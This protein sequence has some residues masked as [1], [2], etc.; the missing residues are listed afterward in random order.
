MGRN[1]GIWGLWLRYQ[2]WSW[3][4]PGSH[5]PLRRTNAEPGEMS[6]KLLV[7]AVLAPYG[8]CPVSPRESPMV[9]TV[10]QVGSPL[11]EFSHAAPLIGLGAER[12][13]ASSP[14]CTVRQR[15]HESG[16]DG[17]KFA[18][19][20]LSVWPEDSRIC[21]G[22]LPIAFGS[23]VP[24]QALF[25]ARPLVGSCRPAHN[26]ADRRIVRQRRKATPRGAHSS[27]RRKRRNR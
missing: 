14:L 3:E 11:P 13:I 9:F 27:D 8:L 1:G 25:R 17:R 7:L 19:S 5:D 24:F 6:M 22:S 23:S 26:S 16:V 15:H 12:E 4:E 10:R 21:S 2:L 18:S 20:C